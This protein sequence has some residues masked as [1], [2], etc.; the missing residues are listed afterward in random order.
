[1]LLLWMWRML[2]RTDRVEQGGWAVGGVGV[3]RCYGR[4]VPDCR[5]ADWVCGGDVGL[6]RGL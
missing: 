3:M 5:W 1:M 6:V 4:A 2:A